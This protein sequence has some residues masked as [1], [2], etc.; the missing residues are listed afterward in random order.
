MDQLALSAADLAAHINYDPHDEMSL[1]EYL[2]PLKQRYLAVPVATYD[3]WVTTFN[4]VFA[5]GYDAGYYSYK[6][7][8]A[9]E[10]D[11]FSR[12]ARDGVLNPA[13]G[14][15]YRDLVLARGS[16]AEPDE[17]IT[18]FLERPSNL[19]AMLE[20][21]GMS[22]HHGGDVPGPAVAV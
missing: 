18:A 16:E 7:A 3:A 9:I 4:H 19:D 11:L 6:W 17:L 14:H 12:F 21:D 22:T 15:R 2:R 13:V 1:S 20:R 10:A 8:E 5:G